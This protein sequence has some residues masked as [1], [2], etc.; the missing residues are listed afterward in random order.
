[1][2]KVQLSLIWGG[3][4][5]I[6]VFALHGCCC[7]CTAVTEAGSVHQLIPPRLLT[8][9]RRVG[10]RRRSQWSQ[11][12]QR[13]P[14]DSSSETSTNSYRSNKYKH[15]QLLKNTCSSQ[16]ACEFVFCEGLSQTKNSPTGGS[17]GG[18]WRGVRWNPSHHL[19]SD[20]SPCGG[21]LVLRTQNK[22]SLS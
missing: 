5:T 8:L 6:L 15:W 11:F 21:R 20:S 16:S 19:H 22:M 10:R 3:G 18:C 14:P 4:G 9:S 2:W 7:Q 13:W 12:V 17:W 1:M